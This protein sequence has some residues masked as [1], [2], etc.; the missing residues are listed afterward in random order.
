M[1]KK[2]LN[3]HEIDRVINVLPISLTRENWK[4]K[5][6]IGLFNGDDQ[7]LPFPHAYL[8]KSELEKYVQIK[9]EQRKQSFIAG[10]LV[11]KQTLSY[12]FKE[13]DLTKIAIKPGIFNQPLIDYHNNQLKYKISLSHSSDQSICLVFPEEH[14][15]GIDMETV[16]KNSGMD[17]ASQLTSYEK[18]LWQNDA[19]DIDTF[20]V[21]LWTIKEALSKV[22]HTGLTVPLEIYEIEHIAKKRNFYI[23]TFKNFGQYKVIS[24]RKGS[25]VYS[26][27]LPLKTDCDLVNLIAYI[28]T[29]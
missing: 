21:L 3:L 1:T 17:I 19:M 18:S 7:Q 28:K 29:L 20:Y 23:S 16:R 26:F 22:L 6:Y 11:A 8:H 14:P 25:N 27:A 13:N 2:E 12:L 24:F 15:M 10:R 5:A 9:L 4:G